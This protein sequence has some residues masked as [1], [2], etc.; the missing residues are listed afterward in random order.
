MAKSKQ[1]ADHRA[2]TRGSPWMGIPHVVLKSPAYHHLSLCARA[3]LTEMVLAMNGYNNGHIAISQ[4]QLA[5]RLRT[6]NFG[7]IGRAI[8]ELMEHGLIDI[9]LEGKWKQRLAREY[10]LTFVSSG[11]PGHYRPATNEYRSWS[12]HQF[13]DDKG[14]AESSI[15]ASPSSAKQQVAADTASADFLLYTRKAKIPPADA[16]SSLISK[17]YLCH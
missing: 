3:I 5:L 6:S 9:A 8:G 14:S 15:A 17:P 12:P 7:K 2:D 1:K 11:K 16:S 4:R 13:G 10:R